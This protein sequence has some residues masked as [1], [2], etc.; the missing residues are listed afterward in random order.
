MHLSIS[1]RDTETQRAGVISVILREPVEA[2]VIDCWTQGGGRGPTGKSAVNCAPGAPS[3]AE[4]GGAQA[5]SFSGG[6]GSAPLPVTASRPTPAKMTARTTSTKLA[7]GWRRFRY[8]VTGGE[9]TTA[10]L[11]CLLP[12][13]L[14][15]EALMALQRGRFQDACRASTP[16]LYLAGNHHSS[17]LRVLR[18]LKIPGAQR[19]R[20]P[21]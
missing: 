9:V 3:N 19:L 7:M 1:R 6:P 13:G 5:A 4:C 20:A 2:P 18:A 14:A 12:D 16:S 8:V 10:W 15:H 21:S 11:G 17:A